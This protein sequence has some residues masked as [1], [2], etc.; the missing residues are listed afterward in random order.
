L[1]LRLFLAL[2]LGFSTISAGAWEYRAVEDKM[3]G[4]TTHAAHVLSTN[5]VQFAFPYAG[6]SRLRLLLIQGSSGRTVVTVHISKGQIFCPGN[7]RLSVKFDD[8]PVIAQ[9][10]YGSRDGSSDSVNLD[11][12]RFMVEGLSGAK[13]LIVEVPFYQQGSR[14]FDFNVEGL[15]WPPKAASDSGA[16]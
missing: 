2:I 10:A 15:V 8:G 5:S 11:S 3:R 1:R 14:Q 7:C 16:N 13:R 9:A 6:G 12:G 4:T